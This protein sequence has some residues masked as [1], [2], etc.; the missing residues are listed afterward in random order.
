MM[1]RWQFQGAIGDSMP[2][3]FETVEKLGSEPSFLCLW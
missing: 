1:C 3:L 2:K